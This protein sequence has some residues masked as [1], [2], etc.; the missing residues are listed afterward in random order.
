MCYFDGLLNNVGEMNKNVACSIEKARRELEYK[1]KIELREG[2]L[3]LIEWC[4]EKGI[5]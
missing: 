5:L 3:R 1:P 4:R 2:M